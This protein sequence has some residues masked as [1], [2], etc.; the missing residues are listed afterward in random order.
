[1]ENKPSMSRVERLHREKVTRYSIR[2]YSFGAAS[3]AVAA[4]FMFLGNGAVSVQ[5]DQIQPGDTATAQPATPALDKTQLESYIS[6]VKSKLSA[7][8]YA[9]KTEESLALLNGKLASAE[10][11][12]AS[13]TTQDEL[14]TAYQ[15]LVMF[16][17]SGLKN[18]PKEAPKVDTTNGQPTV[19]KKAENTEPKS[20]SNSIENTGSNDARNGQALDKN[21][22]FRADTDTEKPT[23]EIPFANGKN[24]YVYSGEAEGF[25]IKIKD[26]SG[27][28]T[29]AT[30]KQGGNRDFNS[31]AGET[32][33]RDVQYVYTINEITT[34]T[35]ASDAS[36][37]VIHYSGVPGGELSAAQLEKIRT[38]GLTLGWRYVTATDE[39][40]NFIENRAAGSSNATDPGSFNVIAKPQTFKYDPVE[41][42][43][44]DKVVVADLA[45]LTETDLNNIKNGLKVEYSKTNDDAQLASKKGTL[46]DDAKTVVSSVAQSGSDLTVTYKDG[47]TDSIAVSSVA[48]VNEKP[49]AEFPFSNAAAKEIY[50]Y[51]AEENSFDIKI[52]DDSGKISSAT[53]RR[54][55]NREFDPVPGATNKISTQ[56]GYTATTI[57]TETPATDANPAVITYSGTPAATDGV[58]QDKLDAATRGE[59]PAGLTLG[60]RFLRVADADGGEI[61]GSATGADDPGSFVVILKPQIRCYNT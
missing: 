1:M 13:A 29:S 30:V 33:K 51:G 50:V 26:N 34:K 9:N 37:A 49:T 53:V 54:G 52:K 46:L 5:A 35:P 56:Y 41:L 48:R 18:K 45:Q 32:D 42:A 25:D 4:L 44:A 20:D 15:K 31:V 23:V 36:P 61:G 43:T 22:A 28:I 11:V 58:K 60:W 6:E 8:K 7:G 21:N 10:S 19:G 3:V 38:T 59:T 2:K 57:T 27:F 14:T 24:V 39:A 12:L 16:V 47:S 55:G 17:S 40:G